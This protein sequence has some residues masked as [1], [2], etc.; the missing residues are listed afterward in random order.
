MAQVQHL[1]AVLEAAEA[2]AAAA[3]GDYPSSSSDDE[4]EEDD[5]PSAPSCVP[6][7][8]LAKGVG[9]VGSGGSGGVGG[10]GGVG[11]GSSSG[12]GGGGFRLNLSAV[13]REEVDDTKPSAVPHTPKEAVLAQLTAQ[14]VPGPSMAFGLPKLNLASAG[15]A[16]ATSSPPAVEAPPMDAAAMA[17]VQHLRAVLEAAEAKAAAASGDYPSSSSDDEREEDDAPS[18][19]SCV[20]PLG[21]A[22]G[23]GGVGSGGSGGVGGVGGVGGG[24]S[25]GG[26]GGGFRLNLSAVTREEVDDT[27]PSAVPHTPKEAVLA[28]LTAQAVPG[29]ASRP[30]PVCTADSAPSGPSAPSAPSAPRA[31]SSGCQN[32]HTESRMSRASED[33]GSGGAPVRHLLR[34]VSAVPVDTTGDGH[35]D[36]WA[37]DSNKVSPHTETTRSV[38]HSEA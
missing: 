20:P 32:S 12:G 26:G 24:S 13:T 34:Q 27:K 2:K 18:A 4:R 19:P 17:Q 30:Q 29:P 38:Q 31:P 16:S 15:L 3:S 14:A 35:A 22:K 1:R 11:G 5:A 9:G 8:G 6:P 36:A 10:V 25:S 28:Q 7:L 21:L 23:V 37:I 33:T